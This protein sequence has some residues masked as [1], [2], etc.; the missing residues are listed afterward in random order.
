MATNAE[1]RA[2]HWDKKFNVERAMAAIEAQRPKM[3]ERYEAAVTALC[4]VEQEVRQV[5]NEAG[6]QT[7]DYIWY[8]SFGRE[9]FRLSRR[10][11]IAGDSLALAA[12]VLLAKWQQRGLDEE[13]LAT[14]RSQ[15]FSVGEPV[16]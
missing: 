3:L 14:I 4:A 5:L 7:I 9:L 10:K 2:R 1:Q 15:V 6:V 11:D 12:Q 8:L 13:V 16:P